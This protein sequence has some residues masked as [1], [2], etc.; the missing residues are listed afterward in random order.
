[1]LG[2]SNFPYSVEKLI[3][4]FEETLRIQ[5]ESAEKYLVTLSQQESTHELALA[6]TIQK[7]KQYLSNNFE[8]ANLETFYPKLH[9]FIRS[10]MTQPKVLLLI[11]NI[12][13]N[14]VEHLDWQP[15][16]QVM[17]QQF[18][19]LNAQYR[20]FQYNFTEL[21]AIFTSLTHRLRFLMKAIEK[22]HYYSHDQIFFVSAYKLM[23]LFI[24]QDHINPSYTILCERMDEIFKNR[25]I[26]D[27]LVVDIQNLPDKKSLNRFVEWQPLF[28]QKQGYWHAI[29][30]F[31]KHAH[32]IEA[33]IS[34]EKKLNL[35]AIKDAELTIHY[36]RVSE[37]EQF[38]D[39]CKTYDVSQE[40]F[41]ECL[42][43][44]QSGWPKKTQDKLPN[45][46]IA[47]EKNEFFW[48]KLPVDDKRALILG[49]ITDCCQSIG[50]DSHACVV[51]GISRQNNGFYVLLERIKSVGSSPITAIEPAQINYQDFRILAQSYAW[52]SQ[53]GNLCLDSFEAIDHVLQYFEKSAQPEKAINLTNLL[54]KFAKQVLIIYPG[55]KRV[56]LGL[57]GKTPNNL[58]RNLSTGQRITSLVS[59][60]MRE[61]HEYGDAKE[62]YRIASC[63]EMNKSQQKR[64]LSLMTSHLGK[65]SEQELQELAVVKYLLEHVQNIDIS[66]EQ[67]EKLHKHFPLFKTYLSA[68]RLPR[69]IQQNFNFEWEVFL[70]IYPSDLKQR[71]VNP[72]QLAW[73][74]SNIPVLSWPPY[75]EECSPDMIESLL[76]WRDENHLGLLNYTGFNEGA[77]RWF[78]SPLT[79]QE[80]FKIA[81]ETNIT[82]SICKLS[83]LELLF[84]G[85]NQEQKFLLLAKLNHQAENALFHI[86]E[87]PEIFTFIWSDLTNPQKII[88]ISQINSMGISVLFHPTA[89]LD[90]LALLLQELNSEQK[91]ALYMNKNLNLVASLDAISKHP[92][93]I[94]KLFEGLNAEQK[95]SIL[96]KINSNEEN[97]LTCLINTPDLLEC[98]WKDLTAE[99]KQ[100]ILAQ[101]N[102]MDVPILFYPTLTLSALEVLLKDIS[103]DQKF[104]LLMAENVNLADAFH[105]IILNPKYLPEH[106]NQFI[107]DEMPEYTP[108]NVSEKIMA[109]FKGFSPEQKFEILRKSNTDGEN[110]LFSL[111][112]T[113]EILH[114][115]WQDLAPKQKLY[116][117]SQVDSLG[118]SIL[119]HPAMESSTIK[120]LLQNIS[121]DQKFK[122]LMDE[123]LCLTTSLIKIVEKSN[124][125]SRTIQK[126]IDED[127]PN[128][129]LEL[130]QGLSG[131]QKYE[132]LLRCVTFDYK[133]EHLI[134][135]DDRLYQSIFGELEISQ[136]LTLLKK[137]K[138]LLISA[139]AFP[140]KLY[141]M[142]D[143][144]NLEQI[145]EIA[146]QNLDDCNYPYLYILTMYPEV[147][148]AIFEKMT[149]NEKFAI[150]CTKNTKK[151]YPSLL[152]YTKR[153]TESLHVLLKDLT[154]QQ[155]EVLAKENNSDGKNVLELLQPDSKEYEIILQAMSNSPIDK[156]GFFAQDIDLVEEKK[157]SLNKTT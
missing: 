46:I 99:Q 65:I 141:F 138:D 80:K 101:V 84:I 98:V 122:L 104:V 50:G 6:K 94:L 102:S 11:T 48:V 134:I 108:K 57:G 107:Q 116:L 42:D 2:L 32:A 14:I 25:S 71:T 111:I 123:S 114:N 12:K 43:I 157:Q 154:P 112:A 21:Q 149:S 13:Q 16:L 130:F 119:F 89:K 85:L 70:P 82:Q 110:T 3:E 30:A 147:L 136:L 145:I 52:I 47:D 78:L 49:E 26:H 109:L 38:A 129:L 77:F 118:V 67:L 100:T 28:H 37:D 45:L 152:E 127:K 143:R 72:L 90:L 75:L 132:V 41:N 87:I 31:A 117:I 124:Y 76:L 105:W 151:P 79:I 86:L 115:L 121:P 15:E 120:F 55:I 144:F 73:V 95:F 139:S 10:I 61:G 135:G 7:F 44:I 97:A 150:L 27:A 74:L 29:K 148:A 91:F 83:L 126:Q 146:T 39:I 96:V 36:Q 153:I 58:F 113:P 128:V 33:K 1:M 63:L 92:E 34:A 131:C 4:R 51:D 140:Q 133:F 40:T 60:T 18:Q 155:V 62:Q 17:S 23:A 156:H 137:F 142:I 125:L 66:L 20:Y 68:D 53:T 8:Q 9:H 5:Q 103:I 88:L 19:T 24:N 93:Y 69:L 59:E 64:L 56:T 22:N 81:I 35:K 54:E 106:I